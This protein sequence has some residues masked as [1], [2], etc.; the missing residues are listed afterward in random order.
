VQALRQMGSSARD[1]IAVLQTLK[2]AN[3]LDAELEVL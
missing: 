3:A 1:V 2:A